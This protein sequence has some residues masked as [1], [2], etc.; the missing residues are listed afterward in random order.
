MKKL[1][2]VDGVDFFI[3]L[4]GAEP[5]YSHSHYIPVTMYQQGDGEQDF[6]TSVPMATHCFQESLNGLLPEVR[7]VMRGEICKIIVEED[8]LLVE[9]VDLVWGRPFWLFEKVSGILGQVV[10][11]QS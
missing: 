10:D 6:D 9:I 7:P 8:A 5:P 11:E 1:R 2:L 4:H 3:G